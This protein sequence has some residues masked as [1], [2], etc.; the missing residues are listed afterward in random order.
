MKRGKLAVISGPSGVG[1]DTIIDLFI[2]KHPD[3]WLDVSV[4]T[5]EPRPNEVPGKDM[6]FVSEAEFQ[7]MS[8]EGKFIEALHIVDYW[9]ASLREPI[10]QR[11]AQGLNVFIRPHPTALPAIKRFYPDAI[12]LFVNAENW[13]ALETRLRARHTEDGAE[14]ERRLAENKDR[15]KY[16]DQYDHVIINPTGHPEAA[17]TELEHILGS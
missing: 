12:S 14:L 8:R 1:Q 17:V 9:Y 6:I 2:A 13:K 7:Q 10:D 15:L 5:R 4:T 3:W 16:Q 11:L